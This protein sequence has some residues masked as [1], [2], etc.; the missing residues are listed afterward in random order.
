LSGLLPEADFFRP[1]KI[2][3]PFAGPTQEALR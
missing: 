2:Y 1:D 3:Q